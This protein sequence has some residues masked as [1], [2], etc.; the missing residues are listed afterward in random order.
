[1]KTLTSERFAERVET[2][3]VPCVLFNEIN[4]VYSEISS[5]ILMQGIEP[6]VARTQKYIDSPSHNL[7]HLFNEDNALNFETGL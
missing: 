4:V 7:K 2:Q 6:F 5:S 3:L 1:M